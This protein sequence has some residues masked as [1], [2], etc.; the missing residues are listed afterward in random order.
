MSVA[1]LEGN[2]PVPGD[3]ATGKGT[4]TTETSATESTRPQWAES[5]GTV[6]DDLTGGSHEEQKQAGRA[7]IRIAV[8][9]GEKLRGP[10]KLTGDTMA[11]HFAWSPRWW[12]ERLRE[13]REAMRLHQ[14]D[15]RHRLP[16]KPLDRRP[17]RSRRHGGPA[18][19]WHEG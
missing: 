17:S 2:K 12:R 1:T 5:L 18:S 14:T 11:E 16:G 3:Q 8:D 19:R 13:V 6:E 4:E 9:K 7:I 15:R 10:D